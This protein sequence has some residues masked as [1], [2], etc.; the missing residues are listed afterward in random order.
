M[1]SGAA[2]FHRRNLILPNILQ[3]RSLHRSWDFEI[4]VH[5]GDSR[6][7]CCGNGYGGSRS[8]GFVG[9]FAIGDGANVICL[10]VPSTRDG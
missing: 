8:V 4:D 10:S 2:D 7:L 1:I 3:M 5:F 6:R 9:G